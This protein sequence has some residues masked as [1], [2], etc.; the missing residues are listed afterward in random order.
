MMSLTGFMNKFLKTILSVSL[1]L[2]VIQSQAQEVNK[3]SIRSMRVTKAT[4]KWFSGGIN[5]GFVSVSQSPS[6]TLLTV[7]DG[8]TKYT[9]SFGF[10]PPLISKEEPN[11]PPVA[12][13]PAVAVFY[14]EGD[15]I[16]LD[17]SDPDGDEIA[18]EVTEQPLL[19]ELTSSGADG[20]KFTFKPSASLTPG[21]GYKDTVR[22]K[23][24]ETLKDL[25]S[26]VA[27]YAFT[28]NVEDKGH[29]IV[30]FEQVTATTDQKTFAL[31]FEDDQFNNDY[32]VI[33]QYIDL[34]DPINPELL[35]ISNANV[36]L[37]GLAVEGNRLTA[38]IVANAVNFPYLFNANKVFITAE[39]STESGFSDDDAFI[40]DNA[41]AG[42]VIEV[43]D[44]I[45][46]DV[47]TDIRVDAVASD[48]GQ[49]FTFS[50]Q[51][52]TPENTDVEL[53]LFAIELGDF[54][55]SDADIQI[56]TDP[57]TGN[58]SDPI[59]EKQTSGL[60]QWSVTYSPVGEVGYLD[61]L[62][63]TVD[64]RSRDFAAS[65][66]A[67][68]EVVDVNDPP[69]LDD[70]ANQVLDEEGTVTVDLSFDD[71][72]GE[73]NLIVT[74]ADPDNLPV[75]VNGNQISVTGA[76]DF[77]GSV[78]VNVLVQE[79]DTDDTYS[80]SQTITFKVEAVNDQP[81]LEA[82]TD[83]AI[84]EDNPFTYTLVTS[85]VDA[86]LPI[87]AYAVLPDVP[88]VVDIVIDGNQL[89]IAP[90]A[91][92]NGVVNFTVTA[93]DQTGQSNSISEAQSFQLTI[94][95]VNDLPEITS[96]IPDQNL[97]EGFPTYTIDLGKYFEDVE[98]ADSDLIYSVVEP[99]AL[100]NLSIA[101]DQL[102]VSPIAGQAGME[103]LTILVSDGEASISQVVDFSLEPVSADIQVSNAI[104]DILLT[105]DFESYTI[106]LANV[107]IDANDDQAVFTFN[108]SGLDNL[109]ATINGTILIITT[110]ANY[111]GSEELI[112]LGN[113][114]D[115]SSFLSF[116]ITVSPVNDEPTIDAVDD[117]TIQED[118]NL[119]NVFATFDDIDNTSDD[120]TVTVSSSNQG[121]IKDES[122]SLTKGETGVSLEATPEENQ[123]GKTTITLT[124]SD[125]ELMTSTEFEV[126]VNSVNDQPEVIGISLTGAT[127]DEAYTVDLSTLFTDIDEDELQYTFE[128]KPEWLV[129]T[130]D[131]LT[132]SP[133][134]DDVG[135]ASF[136]I[137]ANDGSGGTVRQEYDLTVTNTN[138]APEVEGGTADV[139]VAEDAL[140]SL[141][142]SDNA[143]VDVDGDGLSF[144]ASFSG[145]SWLSFD[146]QINRFVGTPANND[147]G[148]VDITVTATDPDGAFATDQFTLTV[149]NTNDS[150]TAISSSGQNLDE[151]SASGSEI[152]TLSTEDVDVGDSH[153]YSLVAGEGATDNHSF[154]IVDGAIQTTAVFNF[155][156]QSTLS[157]RVRSTDAA[158]ATVDEVIA[159]TVGD[160]NEAPT[161]LAITNT[162]IAENAAIGTELGSLSSVDQDA[163]D[164]FDYSLVSGSGDDDNASF[165]VSGG[166]LVSKASFDFETKSA[167]TVRLQTSDANGL[168][169]EKALAITVNNANEAPTVLGVSATT[170]V[171]NAAAGTEVGSLS[172]EDPD[173]SDSHT[174]TLVNGEGDD[175]N[176]LF[177]ISNGVLVSD[178]SLN[179]EERSAYTVRIATAD[180]GGLSFEQS[181]TVT[182]TDAN[183]T[184]AD[185]TADNLSLPENGASGDVIGALSTVDE[186]ALDSHTY[187][188]VAGAGSDD[189]AS[190]ELDGNQIRA[191][192]TFNFE[193]K[194][195]YTI[196]IST[197]DAGGL[198]TE[199]AMTVTVTDANDM[200]TDITADNLSVAE[201]GAA[202]DV[203][204][205]LFTQDED[206][207]DSHIYMLVTGDGSDDNASF[208]LDGNELKALEAFDF[209]TKAI[210][211]IR[212]STTDVGG[213][214]YEKSLTVTVDNQPE[215]AIEDITGITFDDTPNGE[216][217]TSSFTIVNS[218]DADIE[219]T[220][221]AAPEGFS[222][223][224]TSLTVAV[225]A[226]A[227]VEV[228]F[229]P[230]E[231][232]TYT[233]QLVM[234]S[235]AGQT[236]ID[237]T[238]IGTVVT[239]I[240]DDVIAD[241]D[242]SLYPNP[243]STTVVIDL[244]DV[245]YL[246]PDI[247][248][249]TTSGVS[250]FQRESVT[251]TKLTLD[252]GQYNAG[253]YLVRIATSKGIVVKKLMIVR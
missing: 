144:T 92:Y 210:Y 204:G 56:T 216:S 91:D 122:I 197:I 69:Q 167:Y 117:Q 168:S 186:D 230:T 235:N 68:V 132:G 67:K 189:N 95:A 231:A 65:S 125:G 51:R 87:F 113:T 218:G 49:F 156:D 245:V 195:S 249:L 118:F 9:G 72:D 205:K 32:K 160:V 115:K 14:E 114:N 81:V 170:L 182:V 253:A 100:F 123:F 171:E 211:S 207:T 25:E 35:I 148:T 251:D 34:S 227:N 101:A 39:V 99:S 63:F 13:V 131:Q 222:V 26:E 106:D 82:I 176:A 84:D 85:D 232:K 127:E 142:I 212:V 104:D 120:L 88:G 200:P 21:N 15:I 18:F 137:I 141:E 151:N 129:L 108:T 179:F 126:T 28:F 239:S 175:D 220:D 8:Q 161:D 164:S 149:T 138:D 41:A 74:S 188:L 147:V 224:T 180:A 33:L 206:A 187:A 128:D 217:A 60:A 185:V 155:E 38:T 94:N 19:G 214:P 236:N 79:I 46:K 196:R 199:K 3:D 50:S 96:Q 66:F 252:V 158:G 17:G 36:P 109:I 98:T 80:K 48:D 174:Y 52:S 119:T 194:S 240:D 27:A 223:A 247:A 169:F 165:E 181:V 237:V 23:V 177:A 24:Y 150:P 130:N 58:F 73:L 154:T 244:T 193:V 184:P 209:E 75:T 62:E 110:P 228:T 97:I 219:V 221:I 105:E 145:A 78:N 70:V 53:K 6:S 229:S 111:N 57:K 136:T 225:G 43:T 135:S 163:G 140:L 40:L 234:T 157:I 10:L 153:T 93:D 172:T 71:P 192:A 11:N 55:L 152:G 243:A 2:L 213:A 61:S 183:D 86:A 226:S 242:I 159:I 77:N 4:G 238:G 47:F 173:V 7:T 89:T 44:D 215:P 202:G 83:Q 241:S 31:S 250:K 54:D 233:G 246:R 248:I 198:S 146:D 5:L 203:V 103:S 121:L 64:N 162:S 30:S 178:A 20:N 16:K 191:L 42:S 1:L 133:E 29:R 208:E 124:L 166:K 76:V 201:N 107:F 116:D 139:E 143:F 90:D 37:S 59:I 22:F 102:S 190:F 134:N 12:T 112:L 45:V